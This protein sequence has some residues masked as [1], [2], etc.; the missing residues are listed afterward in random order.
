LKKFQTK[1]ATET[2]SLQVGGWLMADLTPPGLGVLKPFG[3][4][5][6]A[7][8]T[9]SLEEVTGS[10]G[11]ARIDGVDP[12]ISWTTDGLRSRE[13]QGLPVSESRFFYFVTFVHFVVNQSGFF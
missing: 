3:G 7:K 1:R 11:R 6:N 9:R 10:E 2:G 8:G 4:S 5:R 12:A 13:S